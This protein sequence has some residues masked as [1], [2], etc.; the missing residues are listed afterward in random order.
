MQHQ[1][2]ATVP[3][4]PT[5]ARTGGASWQAREDNKQGCSSVKWE[6]I[7]K[8]E[9]PGYKLS[10]WQHEYNRNFHIQANRSESQLSFK[11]KI[12]T[13]F[14]NYCFAKSLNPYP[15]SLSYRNHCHQVRAARITVCWV[16]LTPISLANLQSQR[17]VQKDKSTHQDTCD[18][19]SEDYSGSSADPSGM[20]EQEA[21]CCHTCS[22]W[23][24]TGELLHPRLG[25]LWWKGPNRPPAPLTAAYFINCSVV[26]HG[27]F[28]T[29]SW[30]NSV[31]TNSQVN[32]DF[33]W[34]YRIKRSVWCH[35]QTKREDW[36]MNVEIR[37]Y[38]TKKREKNLQFTP[39]TILYL[40][41]RS[42]H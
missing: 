21:I 24:K 39:S 31:F 35:V 7:S 23:Q 12:R 1:N 13:I 14:L 42:W 32:P 19:A 27:F 16:L 20:A 37:E 30:F 34:Q 17:T 41:S 10:Y 15:A 4:P 3:K 36:N 25:R 18:P 38:W 6:A 5:A 2:P 28:V 9:V 11:T 40:F 33:H 26:G 8:A 29:A 22:P